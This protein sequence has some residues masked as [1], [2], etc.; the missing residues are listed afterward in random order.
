MRNLLLFLAL[1]LGACGGSDDPK[2]TSGDDDDDDTTTSGDDDD[3][4]GDD[5]D[6]A[7]GDDDDTT[8]E[9]PCEPPGQATL[10][11][12]LGLSGYEPLEDGD[13]FPLIHGPQGGY[14][15]EVGLLATNL[16][17][18]GLVNGEIIGR[19]DGMD[20][21]ATSYPRL[22]LRCV[23]THRESYGT[24]LVFP[25]AQTYTPDFLD[26]KTVEI[27]ATVTDSDGTVV[28]TLATFVIEDT[29]GVN[30]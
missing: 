21:D 9:D 10:E 26:G 11:I 15:L 24:L 27:E 5:D 13:P 14:H 12:G 1:G 30:P 17:I 3:T 18:D 16:A 28:T 8:D 6:D 20:P 29:E 19:V 25:D 22:D 7:T 23:N 2:D 4:T